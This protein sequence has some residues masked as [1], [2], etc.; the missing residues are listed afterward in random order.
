MGTDGIINIPKK[1]MKIENWKRE[2][3]GDSLILETK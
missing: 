1:K 3:S 2:T